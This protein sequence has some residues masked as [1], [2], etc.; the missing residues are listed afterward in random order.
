M[1]Q[2]RA[3]SDIKK[4]SA[5]QRK[6][7]RKKRAFKQKK[8][9]ILDTAS[10]FA[11]HQVVQN[12]VKQSSKT[13]GEIFSSVHAET[14]KRQATEAENDKKNTILKVIQSQKETAL[15][16]NEQIGLMQD[17]AKQFRAVITNEMIKG[18]EEVLNKLNDEFNKLSDKKKEGLQ[19]LT[20]GVE[21]IQKKSMNLLDEIEKADIEGDIKIV[22][23]K[24]K[25]LEKTNETI[26]NRLDKASEDFDEGIAQIASNLREQEKLFGDLKSAINDLKKDI[27]DEFNKILDNMKD[28]TQQIYKIHP[29]LAK[30]PIYRIYWCINSING[31]RE[32]LDNP[33]SGWADVCLLADVTEISTGEITKTPLPHFCHEGIE[34][35]DFGEQFNGKIQRDEDFSEIFPVCLTV[36]ERIVEEG[37]KIKILN[38][39]VS[40]A[41]GTFS[42]IDLSKMKGSDKKKA[43]YIEKIKGAYK[44]FFPGANNND[45][46]A[47]ILNKEL[48][49]LYFE[50]VEWV[51]K[52]YKPPSEGC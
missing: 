22:N 52:N 9:I 21:E 20:V 37:R 28:V 49:T 1:Q 23:E 13:A 10:T 3:F 26:K 40:I 27:S 5:E 25:E 36:F 29:C 11:N 51:V 42:E 45:Y 44:V 39:N 48:Y 2:Q 32:N 16:H 24:Q 15:L 30:E 41:F 14:S 18:A 8:Q 47:K 17:K 31:C 12:Q 7:D 46:D 35:K 4:K 6:K 33:N 43:Y 50:S 38:N 34:S 19:I